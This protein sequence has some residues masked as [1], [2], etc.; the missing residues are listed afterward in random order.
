M[1]QVLQR[2]RPAPPPSAK[3]TSK[4][5]S[6]LRSFIGGKRA[7]VMLAVVGGAA[8][9]SQA[10]LTLLRQGSERPTGRPEGAEGRQASAPSA[11][12]A[13]SRP[14]VA[15]T[16]PSPSQAAGSSGKAAAGSPTL[17]GAVPRSGSSAPARPSSTRKPSGALV[18]TAAAGQ[19]RTT[20]SG[21]PWRSRPAG[22]ASQGVITDTSSQA[23][24]RA[25]P[26]AAARIPSPHPA[27]AISRGSRGVGQLG[28]VTLS[29]LDPSLGVPCSETTASLPSDVPPEDAWLPGS[30][31]S[32]APPS[33]AL[34][35]IPVPPI[36]S[37]SP[38][39]AYRPSPNSLHANR[40]SSC[41]PNQLS[42]RN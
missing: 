41:Q 7:L 3:S 2:T 11:Q 20:G 22:A 9:S 5:R 39:Q 31:A 36:Y 28:T 14:T 29:D 21:R 40:T 17:L 12:P 24:S 18:A 38:D 32:S 23:P 26:A 34:D 16:A 42:G 6:L 33:A 8:L 35:P 1:Q 15:A 19:A 30:D 13:A 4:L 10:L 25:V 37:E 27:A